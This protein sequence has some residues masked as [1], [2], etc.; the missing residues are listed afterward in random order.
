MEKYS[1]LMSVYDKERPEYLH[2]AVSSMLY[3]TV[4]PEEFVLVCDGKLPVQLEQVVTAFCLQYPELFRVVRLEENVGLG[5]ALNAGL[6]HCS[7]ELVAR[8]DSDDIALPRRME[9]QLGEMARDGAISVLGGQIAE[10]AC[11]PEHIT[12]Y[13]M[14][15]VE[16][17]E[18]AAF[19]Q[20]RSPMNHTTTLLRKSHVLA[21][22]GY[23]H[24]LGFED[25]ILWAELMASG[26]RL[27]NVPW[28]CCKVR[29]DAG[30]YYRRGGIRYFRN[31]VKME[32]ILLEKR[33]I[34]NMQFVSNLSIRFL[35]TMVLTPGL[36][37]WAFLHFLRSREKTEG[38]RV[39][40]RPGVY[41]LVGQKYFQP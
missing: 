38:H 9:L 4:P 23:S 13:R 40:E 41:E 19:L 22:G 27:R 37:R 5:R 31:T 25:Y 29:A 33:Q 35:G 7:N 16:E 18:I 26:C 34:T 11:D 32:R 30:M 12:G 14:V 10:F 1:V 15:P 3:Q 28:V 20:Y 36:R 24:V 6:A 17:R 2:A 39:P 21:V 8:M